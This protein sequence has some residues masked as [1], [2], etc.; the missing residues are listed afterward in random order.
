MPHPGFF[1]EHG[2][3]PGRLSAALARVDWSRA[4]ALAR[5]RALIDDHSRTT[6]ALLAEVARA[7]RLS[8]AR[9]AAQLVDKGDPAELPLLWLT[10]RQADRLGTPITL[11]P[12][13]RAL[14]EQAA[15]PLKAHAQLLLTGALPATRL[16][17]LAPVAPDTLLTLHLKELVASGALAQPATLARLLRRAAAGEDRPRA[18]A[19]LLRRLRQQ[20][21]QLAGSY[22]RLDYHDF[23]A[24][25]VNLRRAL[26][27]SHGLPAAFL[28]DTAQA[29]A[30]PP[31]PD[32]DPLYFDRAL[33]DLAAGKLDHLDV[34]TLL[35]G[36][37]ASPMFRTRIVQALANGVGSLDCADDV[38]ERLIAA[39]ELPE[40]CLVAC[41][42]A[43]NRNDLQRALARLPQLP[44]T[45]VL[46]EALH[47]FA[48]IARSDAPQPVAAT[49]PEASA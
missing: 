16:T 37:E 36:A 28:S 11:T 31:S 8:P 45:G 7:R 32:F 2:Y 9:L 39:S 1:H 44:A 15:G 22:A 47:R 23:Q 19:A 25:P 41:A 34:D 3:G 40:I 33:G 43:A 10:L 21:V 46:G 48:Q 12:E 17:E 26:L 49:A 18:L 6:L 29:A 38:R 30:R 20:L 24:L 35:L 4:D 42:V 13:R 5:S 14:L 27:F